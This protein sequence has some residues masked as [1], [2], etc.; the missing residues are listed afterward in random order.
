LILSTRDKTCPAIVYVCVEIDFTS[1]RAEIVV[2]VA[3]IFITSTQSILTIR[4]LSA[5]VVTFSTVIGICGKIDFAHSYDD[6]S[7]VS[8]KTSA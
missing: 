4:I 7:C 3:I 8:C 5:S 1:I 6:A 2:A